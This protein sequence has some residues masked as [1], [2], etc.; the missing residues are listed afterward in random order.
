MKKLLYSLVS[1]LLVFGIAFAQEMPADAAPTEE[2]VLRVPCDNTRNEVTFDFA[3][4]VYQRYAC[5]SDLFQDTLIDLDKDFNVI[6]ASAES[7]SVSEDG[8]TWTF[9]LKPGLMW[10]DGTPLTA[11]DYEATYRFSAMPDTA[12]D[13]TW[14]YSFIG[15]GGIKNWDKVVAGE[16][17]PEELGVVAVDDLT[18]EVTT[19]GPFPPL[20]G[21]MKFAFVLQKAAL[22]A[23]GPYYNN[24]PATSVS[25]GP[26]MLESFDPGNKIVLV[27]NP[28]YTGYRPARLERIEGIY[29]APATFFAAF[30]A[31][32]VD[33]VPYE[34]LTPADFTIIENDPELSANYFRHF[35]DFRTDYLLFDTMNPPFDNLDVRKAFAMA[36]DRDAIVKNVYGEIKAMPAHS[37]LMPGYP[38]SDTEGEL[39]E[40]QAF[41]CEKANEHLAAAGY[42]GGEGFPALEMWLRGEG[43]AMAAVYQASAASIAQCLNID[44]QVSNKDGKVYTDAMNAKELQFG[45]VSYG[46]DFLDPSNL[47]GI[48]VSS[49]RHAWVNEEFDNLVAEASALVGDDEKR[50]QMFKDAERI[51]VD[52][53]GGVFI[54]HRWQGDLFKPYVLG[55]SFR[56]PD[57]NGI[58]GVH[59]GNDNFWGDVYIG[60]K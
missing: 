28:N 11:Y 18:L 13:F 10:S 40:Y 38:A 56:V 6:P 27:K 21:V 14:F 37:M 20:P 44:I 57:S 49:G 24:D 55:D 45:A 4:S 8:L 30:E 52:D 59:W 35:G 41:N 29:M 1:T 26:F 46:M 5:V 22:E 47:L 7:W 16:L 51:L 25:A 9:K 33:R 34:Y 32:E 15:P 42:P 48:W 53:V 2:Q 12:W 54:A 36:L 3:V 17:P 58:S 23:H 60:Q 43:P 31:G 19:E 39:A 50:T